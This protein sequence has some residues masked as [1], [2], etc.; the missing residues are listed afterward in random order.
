MPILR[1]KIR[2]TCVVICRDLH[3]RNR[4][5]LLCLHIHGWAHSLPSLPCT[6]VQEDGQNPVGR[7]DICYRQCEVIYSRR[8]N[9]SSYRRCYI[10]HMLNREDAR[11]R[12]IQFG[13]VI[14]QGLWASMLSWSSQLRTCGVQAPSNNTSVRAADC[15]KCLSTWIYVIRMTEHP[16]M[17]SLKQISITAPPETVQVEHL[18]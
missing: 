15:G 4:L 13:Q 1:Y 18:K 16:S 12:D 8:V 10:Q 11:V 5:L 14:Q 9:C 7:R 6:F 17:V 3:A 2:S